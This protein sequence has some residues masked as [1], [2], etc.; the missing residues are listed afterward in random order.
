MKNN[1]ETLLGYLLEVETVSQ[2]PSIEDINDAIEHVKDA[3]SEEIDEAASIEDF[4]MKYLG[5]LSVKEIGQYDD[6]SSWMERIEDEDELRSFRGERWKRLTDVWGN[7]PPPV[8]VVSGETFTTIGDGR[9]RVTY[10]AYKNI[11]LDVWELTYKR[12]NAKKGDLF[13]NGVGGGEDIWYHTTS[14]ENAEN[15]LRGGLRINPSGKGKSR[16]SLQWMPEAYG[17]IT[18]IFL[19]RKPGRYSNGV[20]LKVDVSGLDLVAD[21]PGLVDFDGRLTDHSIYWD[22]EETP[23]IIWDL[24]DPGTEESVNGELEFE[25]LR[26]PDNDISRAAIELTG[27]AAV[28]QNIDPS[29]IELTEMIVEKN[30]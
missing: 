28:M 22:E 4:E 30:I 16:A 2:R 12:K 9:G 11:P 8:I 15:I 14:R 26:E 3:Y 25:W 1:L 19:S 21:I 5:K 13:E 18:P 27:T 23:E 20:I 29:R 10:A 7:N 6:L 17:G 24:M